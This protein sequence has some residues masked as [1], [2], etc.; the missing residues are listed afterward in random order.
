[1]QRHFTVRNAL[2]LLTILVI[3]APIGGLVL[4]AE[5]Q[6]RDARPA[7]AP[8]LSL[9]AEVSSAPVAFQRRCAYFVHFEPESSLDDATA[10]KLLALNRMPAGNSVF[11]Y[12]NTPRVTDDSLPVLER[13]VG[14][15]RLHL[16]GS[17]LSDAGIKHLQVEL[18]EAD[19][20]GR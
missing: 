12:I 5:L 9:G 6:R 13:L 7:L 14:V 2:V 15:R 18:P 16:A 1:M 19:V 3:S 20:W 8:M 4:V 17:G 11:L 10:E